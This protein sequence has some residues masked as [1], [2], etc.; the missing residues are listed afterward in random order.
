MAK[1]WQRGQATQAC[2]ELGDF[3]GKTQRQS[4]K[5]LTSAQSADLGGKAARLAPVLGC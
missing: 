1:H 5:K 4:G 3:A 2:S